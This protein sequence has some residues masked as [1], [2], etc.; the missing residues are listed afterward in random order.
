MAKTHVPI[1]FVDKISAGTQL[2]AATQL[3]G[4]SKNTKHDPRITL[5]FFIA[6][7]PKQTMFFCSLLS[8]ARLSENAKN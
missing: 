2:F 8:G 6:L 1:F 5:L 7:A 3:S 4:F